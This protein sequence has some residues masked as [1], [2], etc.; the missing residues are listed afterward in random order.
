ML[1]LLVILEGAV[2]AAL[3]TLDLPLAAAVAHSATAALIVV[4]ALSVVFYSRSSEVAAVSAHA[5]AEKLNAAAV[6][7]NLHAG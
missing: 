1:G 4:A 2:G 7:K 3:V 5:R 6:T